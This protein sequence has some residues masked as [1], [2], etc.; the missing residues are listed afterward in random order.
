MYY[1]FRYIQ[2]L[3]QE[4]TA[5][6]GRM[7]GMTPELQEGWVVHLV[8]ENEMVEQEMQHMLPNLQAYLRTQLRNDLIQIKISVSHDE[9][10]HKPTGRADMLRD[11]TEQY[12][13]LAILCERLN[14]EL[15]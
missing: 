4:Q 13:S 6:A 5:M 2:I 3:P 11:L 9:V 1:W 7:K 8:L 12:H 15:A 14:L 10:Q